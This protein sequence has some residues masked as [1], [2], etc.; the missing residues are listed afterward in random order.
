MNFVNDLATSY[1]VSDDR[2]TWTFAISDDARFTDGEPLRA[3][4][5]AF[6]INAVVA[7]SNA[8]TDLSIVAAAALAAVVVWGRALA[9]LATRTDFSARNLAPTLGLAGAP[10]HP[11]GTDWMGRDMLARTI[12][13]LSTSVF[14]G[15]VSTACSSVAALVLAA[16]AALGGRRAD[17][18]SR[19][20]STSSWASRTS[21]CSCL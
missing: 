3:S 1:E 18:W 8:E 9:S 16:V 5:V 13:G 7:S 6:T 19:G 11:F 4:D 14:V 20:S 2:P 21:C 15:L 10:A 12:A 17:R